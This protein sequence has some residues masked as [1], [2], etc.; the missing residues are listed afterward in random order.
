V[1]VERDREESAPIEVIEPERRSV[2]RIEVLPRRPRVARQVA[3]PK[4]FEVA[5]VVASYL[6]QVG[7]AETPLPRVLEAELQQPPARWRPRDIGVLIGFALLLF[8][9][10]FAGVIAVLPR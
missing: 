1:A 2:Q 9:V 8:V 3:L 7:G 4:A 6:R 10:V 5:P